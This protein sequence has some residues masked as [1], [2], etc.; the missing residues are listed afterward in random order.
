MEPELEENAC[1]DHPGPCKKPRR[2]DR[3]ENKKL[4]RQAGV[5]DKCMHWVK[6]KNR[7]RVCFVV[8]FVHKGQRAQD[9]ALPRSTV[10]FLA[11]LVVSS[12]VHMCPEWRSVPVTQQILEGPESRVRSTLVTPYSRRIRTAM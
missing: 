12:V 7:V 5:W 6:S 11:R 2:E 9:V 3:K 8:W 10:A 1:E 4:L